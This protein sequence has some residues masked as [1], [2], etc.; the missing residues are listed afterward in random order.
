MEKELEKQ[1]KFVEKH[2]RLSGIM[3]ESYLHEEPL[4]EENVKQ[5]LH[6]L[7]NELYFSKSKKGIQ[8]S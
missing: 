5:I 7:L 8:E 2:S 1:I 3:D 6:D 4:V